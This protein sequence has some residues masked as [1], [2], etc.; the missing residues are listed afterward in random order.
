MDG[1]RL[2]SRYRNPMDGWHAVGLKYPASIYVCFL[3]TRV[4]RLGKSCLAVS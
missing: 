1:R 3:L 2:I 4:H